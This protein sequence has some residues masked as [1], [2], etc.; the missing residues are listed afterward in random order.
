MTVT[1]GDRRFLSFLSQSLGIIAEVDL[2][3]EHLRWMGSARFTFGLL[4]RVWKQTVFPCDLAVRVAIEGKEDIREHY[5]A[6][7]SGD[8]F[9]DSGAVGLPELKFGTV[10]DP[11]P[12]EWELVHQPNMGNFYAGN[13]CGFGGDLG[14]TRTDLDDRWPGC[15]RAPTSFPR[16]C[17][18]MA[19]LTWCLSM[20][21]L[22]AHRL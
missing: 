22:V 5:R 15:R 7:G 12:Q 10:N 3:T 17:R 2:G 19:C 6:G 9:G 1:Q 16:R 8:N 18:T 13:V 14:W 11:L 4:Q 21:R 20:R